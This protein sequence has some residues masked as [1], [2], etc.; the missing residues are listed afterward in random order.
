MGNGI[1]SRANSGDGAKIGTI[2][3]SARDSLGEKWALCNGDPVTGGGDDTLEVKYHW[4]PIEAS[5][6]YAHKSSEISNGYVYSNI[7][8]DHVNNKYFHIEVYHPASSR[9]VVSIRE[10]FGSPESIDIGIVATDLTT[11]RTST[12]SANIANNRIQSSIDVINQYIYLLIPRRGDSNFIDILKFDIDSGTRLS[13]VLKIDISLDDS[14]NF[15]SNNY[16]TK[17]IPR[18]NSGGIINLGY[19]KDYSSSNSGVKTI[20]YKWDGTSSN[21]ASQISTNPIL[22][23]SY[24]NVIDGGIFGYAVSSKYTIALPSFI[25]DSGYGTKIHVFSSSLFSDSWSLPYTNPTSSVKCKSLITP[26]CIDYDNDIFY[27]VGYDGGIYQISVTDAPSDSTAYHEVELT[28]LNSTWIN[29]A[30]HINFEFA[31][32][33]FHTQYKA[34]GTKQLYMFIVGEE[35]SYVAPINDITTFGPDA[36]FTEIP[37]LQAKDVLTGNV[38]T[39]AAFVNRLLIINDKNNNDIMFYEQSL[40]E[41]D[42]PGVNAFIK[43]KN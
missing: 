35:G 39:D 1:L 3:L 2:R 32:I 31:A 33:K 26:S 23:G 4:K 8:Y 28:L 29:Y 11:D 30:Q 25:F 41:I 14:E 16:I 42:K 34:G 38:L 37:N 9:T 43:I 5:D 12:S 18:P 27:C 40:P 7:V 17:I 22:V 21:S 19:I 36:V 15:P 13:Y 10:I 6:F 20:C 24:G